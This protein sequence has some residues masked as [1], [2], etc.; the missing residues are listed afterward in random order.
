MLY[1]ILF[2]IGGSGADLNANGSKPGERKVDIGERKWTKM[3]SLSL[4]KRSS[5]LSGGIGF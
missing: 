4:R 3:V 1:F 2:Q 5:E